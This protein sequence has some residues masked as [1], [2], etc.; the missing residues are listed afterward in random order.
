MTVFTQSPRAST[1]SWRRR[2]LWELLE[3]EQ[4]WRKRKGG[5]ESHRVCF[6][7]HPVTSI[8]IDSPPL[9]LPGL[10]KIHPHAIAFIH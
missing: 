10:L 3:D 2:G 8:Q 4:I 9:F 6:R 1:G 7:L 5:C